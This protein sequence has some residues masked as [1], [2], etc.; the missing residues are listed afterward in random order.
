MRAELFCK[1]SSFKKINCMRYLMIYGFVFFLLSC[2]DKVQADNKQDESKEPASAA[3][4]VTACNLLKA[5]DAE[6]VLGPDVKPGMQTATMCQYLSGSEE[7]MK[8][9][10]NLSLT[11]HQNAG[12][13]FEKYSADTEASTNVKIESVEGLGQKAAWAEGTLIVKSGADLLVFIV[14]IRA[15]KARHLQ[16]A[17]AVAS[18]VIARR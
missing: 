7:L 6:M 3:S 5:E 18:R 2:S 14:G 8:S 1:H 11:I 10:E 13:E 4:T 9:A 16:L 17:K 12:S 15:D